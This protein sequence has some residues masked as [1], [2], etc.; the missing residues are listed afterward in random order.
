[1][2]ASRFGIDLNWVCTVALAA[3]VLAWATLFL[4][5]VTV[6]M[7]CEIIR[8]RFQRVLSAR[9]DA[10]IVQIWEAVL[11]ETA[12]NDDPPFMPVLIRRDRERV[13]AI[14]CRVGDYVTGEAQQRL[15]AAGRRAGLD[16]FAL[17]IFRPPWTRWRHPSSVATLLAIRAAERMHLTAAWP[18]LERIVR[19]GPAPLDRYAARALVSLDPGRAAKAV[20]PALVRQGR[21]ARHLVED[22]VEAGAARAIEVY[23]ELMVTEGEAAIPGLAL[24]LDR[25][26][27]PRSLVAARARLTAATT[28]DP[29]AIAA[30][31]N[32]LSVVGGKSERRLVQAFAGHE[33][34][35]VRMRAA[36]ALGR[37]GDRRDA[38]LLESLLSD[39]N[40]Y[41][42]YHAARALLRM[43][44][45]GEDFLRSV[46]TRTTDPFAHDM[47]VHVIAEADAPAAR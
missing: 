6:W 1:M 4:F 34:W 13:L 39:T 24:L 11:F 32:T 33:Q 27:D 42:R 12:L 9:R 16:R 22:L 36:Q 5:A 37:C 40:W 31:L 2:P 45:L 30:L 20:L 21:W 7:I 3:P 19:D 17:T 25:C 35:F 46:I 43:P 44:D 8:V 26:A 23:A 18:Q 28:N 10:D 15:A 41:T 47:A 29:E 14:W 38:E